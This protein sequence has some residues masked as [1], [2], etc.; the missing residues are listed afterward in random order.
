MSI[1]SFTTNG[2]IEHFN[3]L[4]VSLFVSCN[5][6]LGDTFAILHYEVFL[7]EVDQHHAYLS[8]IIGIDGA[9]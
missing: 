7:R 9:W 4:K 2:L 6:H 1:S 8:A 3:G 5:H